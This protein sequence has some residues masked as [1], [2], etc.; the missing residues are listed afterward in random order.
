MLTNRQIQ[1][2]VHIFNKMSK[3][4]VNVL[5]TPFRFIF[6]GGVY[7][8]EVFFLLRSPCNSRICIFEIK[9]VLVLF[10]YHMGD[11]KY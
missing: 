11:I 9:I 7:V 6:L 2:K 3:Q 4:L 10:V 5:S 8:L 1:K